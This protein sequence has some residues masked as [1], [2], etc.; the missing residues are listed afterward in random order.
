M[1]D[2]KKK[3]AEEG[4]MTDDQRREFRAGLSAPCRRAL[5]DMLAALPAIKQRAGGLAAYHKFGRGARAL[6]AGRDKDEMYGWMKLLRRALNCSAALITKARDFARKYD[7]REVKALERQKIT[8]GLVCPTLQL[9][10]KDRRMEWMVDAKNGRWTVHELEARI[11][12]AQGGPKRKGGR[13]RRPKEGSDLAVDL[14]R[15]RRACA[16]WLDTQEKVWAAA[17]GPLPKLDELPPSRLKALLARIEEAEQ[18]V[19]ALAREATALYGRLRG[20]R[21]KATRAKVTR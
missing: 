3:S 9:E 21:E 2:R 5:D 11:Q 18:A 12:E 15:L 4:P 17:G 16:S 13:M 14:T 6:C 1:P 8:W 10:D 20:L 19:Q 7:A